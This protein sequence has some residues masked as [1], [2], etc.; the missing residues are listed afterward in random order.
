M[1]SFANPFNGNI[2]EKKMSLYE[3]VRAIRLDI[4]GEHEAIFLY[5]AHADATD[6]PLAKKVLLDI[7]NEERE[8]VGELTQLLKYLVDD[9]AGLLESGAEEVRE[10]AEELAIGAISESSDED[11]DKKT[12]VGS[13][14][15]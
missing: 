12:T 4:A 9:E 1:P 2:P 6:N 14:K 3:L 13:L 10:M 15:E 11:D 7:A 5:Q 8:H